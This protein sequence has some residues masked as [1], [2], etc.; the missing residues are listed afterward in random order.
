MEE[1]LKLLWEYIYLDQSEFHRKTGKVR[2]ILTTDSQHADAAIAL[3]VECREI[4]SRLNSLSLEVLALGGNMSIK[5]YVTEQTKIS[6]AGEADVEKLYRERIAQ[7]DDYAK[8]AFELRK[9]K[10]KYEVPWGGVKAHEKDGRHLIR[11]HV[12]QDIKELKAQRKEKSNAPFVSSFTSQEIADRAALE[13]LANNYSQIQDWLQKAGRPKFRPES[14][15]DF[16]TGYG[17]TKLSNE[18]VYTNKAKLILV[19]D[20]KSLSGYRIITGYPAL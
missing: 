16:Q 17:I 5:D 10:R 19:K 3:T 12:G 1:R 8:Y 7:L 11:D 18:V 13:V 2:F 9:S 6:D 14:N 20:D 4:A 15:C